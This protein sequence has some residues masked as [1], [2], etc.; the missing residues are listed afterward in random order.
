MREFIAA[1]RTW[2][3]APRAC[4]GKGS[5]ITDRHQTFF[6]IVVPCPC[7]L[8]ERTDIWAKA[9]RLRSSECLRARMALH[10]GFEVM[11]NPRLT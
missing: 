1:T 5:G 11:L 6:Y 2:A 3:R 7:F 8:H 10:I 4:C 9:R